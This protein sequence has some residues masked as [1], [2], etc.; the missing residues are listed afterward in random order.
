M[1]PVSC[2]MVPLCHE[3]PICVGGQEI[4]LYAHK[5]VH[6]SAPQG[7]DGNRKANSFD[8]PGIKRSDHT[9]RRFVGHSKTTSFF[10]TSSHYRYRPTHPI[11]RPESATP[12]HPMIHAQ[13]RRVLHYLHDHGHAWLSLCCVPGIPTTSISLERASPAE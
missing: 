1:L 4:A 13:R 7:S 5:V 11:Y 3:L 12:A 2:S 8:R 10:F 9:V 6:S